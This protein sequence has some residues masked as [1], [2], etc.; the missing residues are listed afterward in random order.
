MNIHEHQAKELLGRHG[1]PVQK[2]RAAFTPE[3]AVESAHYAVEEG[4]TLLIVKA[5]IH[6]GGRGKG[7]VYDNST[8]EKIEFDGKD[9]RGVKVIPV[10]EADP[11]H[12]VYEVASRMLGNKLVTVQTGPAGKV[13]NRLLIANGVDIAK[14]FY[15]SI[16]LDRATGR[17]IIMA[18]TEG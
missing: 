2:G 15:C 6:A 11:L 17:N 12:I 13:V 1:V 8:N 4:C 10:S 14:E 9:L 18:S 3:Q 7:I 5:Q 16:L